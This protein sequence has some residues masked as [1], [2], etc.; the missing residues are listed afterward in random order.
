MV[1]CIKVKSG[2]NIQH[3]RPCIDSVWE[4]RRVTRE[5][6]LAL[7][8]SQQEKQDGSIY[9]MISAPSRKDCF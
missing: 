2:E 9:R 4:P 3:Q 7:A 8:G 1:S 5:N 6:F